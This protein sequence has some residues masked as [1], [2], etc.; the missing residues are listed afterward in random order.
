MWGPR[1]WKFRCARDRAEC[2]RALWESYVLVTRAAQAG[3]KKRARSSTLTDGAHWTR[4]K[5]PVH[6][7]T[8]KQLYRSPL[9]PISESHRPLLLISGQG[10]V[11]NSGK[12]PSPVSLSL[13]TATTTLTISGGDF[14]IVRFKSRRA[15]GERRLRNSGGTS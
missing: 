15:L 12:S 13:S 6:Q 10:V 9:Y 5:K 14:Q 3:G 7:S 1:G 2:K 8:T 4:R 11:V